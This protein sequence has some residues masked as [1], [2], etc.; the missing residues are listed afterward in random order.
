M[1]GGSDAVIAGPHLDLVR[2]FNDRS[3]FN[4]SRYD[5]QLGSLGLLQ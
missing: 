2:M 3:R 4:E 5:Q 1:R